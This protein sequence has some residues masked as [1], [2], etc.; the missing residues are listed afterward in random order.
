MARTFKKAIKLTERAVEALQPGA[1][2]T[3]IWDAELKGLGIRLFPSGTRKFVLQYRTA[4]GRQRRLGLGNFPVLTCKEARAQALIKLADIQKGAD[5]SAAKSEYRAAMTVADLCDAYLAAADDGLILGKGGVAKKASTLAT[6]KGRIE[7][8]IKPVLGAMKAMDVTTADIERFKNAVALGKTAKT[9]KTKLRGRAIVK[10]GKGTATRTLGLLGGI[11][12]W[13]RTQGIV[14][15]SPAA[16][17][18]RFAS[19]QRKVIMT[20]EQY[21][22]LGDALAALEAKRTA[23]NKERHHG[24][25]LAAIR[26]LALTGGRRGDAVALRWDWI[27][28]ANATLRLG[29]S[30]TGES[31]R[32]IGRA[33]LDLLGSL[34]R[35]SDHVFA[36]GPDLAG[37]QGLPKL[38]RLIQAQARPEGL[39]AGSPGPLDAITLHS[40]R[41]SFASHADELGCSMPTIAAMLG[42]K[43]GGVTGGYIK[44]ADKPLVASADRVAGFIDRAMRGTEPADNVLD[45]AAARSG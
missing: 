22:A 2:E 29:D 42:Q 3:I 26:F 7:R 32:P 34:P 17:V 43:L 37:Y 38:W 36:A 28:A 33:A 11:F 8:H 15:A 20:G 5:P 31:I 19:R 24:L 23:N 27:D 12:N 40:F 44:K 25:G 1:T 16:G 4:G 6:D 14:A 13:G 9:E 35:L 18:K 30:K 10:G 45:L 21:R 39:P 41:H